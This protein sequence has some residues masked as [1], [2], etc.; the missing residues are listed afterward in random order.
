MEFGCEFKCL[1][2]KYENVKKEIREKLIQFSK[3][4]IQKQNN[5]QMEPT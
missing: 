1:L 4:K 2:V 5:Y 3:T